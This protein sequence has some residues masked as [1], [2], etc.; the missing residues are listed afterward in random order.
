MVGKSCPKL[1]LR[2]IILLLVGVGA[3]GIVVAVTGY[4]NAWQHAW[5]S[6]CSGHMCAIGQALLLYEDHHG[7]LPPPHIDAP[8][9]RRMHSWRAV[10]VADE[11]DIESPFPYS[12]REPWNG[13]NNSRL[14]ARPD[15]LPLACPS[16]PH[17]Q[18]HD[19]LTNYFVI[20][21][22]G[23]LSSGPRDKAIAGV[24]DYE[25][26]SSTVLVAEASGLGIEWLEPRDLPYDQMVFTVNG[27]GG[28]S[29]SSHHLQG[30]NVCM[31]DGSVRLLSRS[32]SPGLL[33]ELVRKK[34]HP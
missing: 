6:N 7:Y 8:D 4:R 16:D 11:N 22:A 17:T 12:F 34:E 26:R 1:P 27:P 9:G 31:A 3:V 15:S 33:R 23:M 20:E 24:E 18:S 32:T 10:I 2:W 30:A 29:I 25:S 19:R 28:P 5:E 14:G 21:G 13:P